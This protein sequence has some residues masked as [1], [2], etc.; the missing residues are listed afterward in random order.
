VIKV[1]V[2]IL[3]SPLLAPVGRDGAFL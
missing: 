3:H 2:G 1:V